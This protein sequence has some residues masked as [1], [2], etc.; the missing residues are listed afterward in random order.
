VN[1]LKCILVQKVGFF[2]K[3]TGFLHGNKM[4]ISDSVDPADSIAVFESEKITT[5]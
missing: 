2:K 3:Y 4:K 1:V 5:L